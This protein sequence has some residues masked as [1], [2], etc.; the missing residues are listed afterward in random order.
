MRC[1]AQGRWQADY[2]VDTAQIFTEIAYQMNIAERSILEPYLGFGYA[3][4][5]GD[6]Y[7][8]NGGF[9]ALSGEGLDAEQ[10]NAILDLTES[11]SIGSTYIGRFSE[12]QRENTYRLNLNWKF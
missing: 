8:E 4:L 1:H 3:S 7:Q 12:D 6:D 2:D 9:S 5:N 10:Y 11:L